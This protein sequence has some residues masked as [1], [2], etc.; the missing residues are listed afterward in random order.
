MRAYQVSAK[1]LV[2]LAL[3]TAVFAACAVLFYDRIGGALLQR[4]AGAKDDKAAASEEQQKLAGISDPSVASDER[5]NQEV[6]RAMSTGVVNITTTT[7]VRD[8]FSVYETT[9]GSGSGSI[10]D[11]E[12]HILTNYHVIE[13]AREIQVSLANNKKYKA[14][15]LGFD[16]DNDLAVL[17]IDAP[18]AELQPIPQGSSKD[19][20]VGQKVLAIGNPFGFDRT[21][22]TGI[23]SGLSRPI[24]SEMTG[25][26]IE[27][28]IQTDAAINPGNSGGPL[29]DSR[30]RQIGINTLIISPSGGSV[31]IG[32]A[33]P[34]EAAKRIIPD[35]LAYGRVR[36][37]KLGIVPLPLFARLSEALNLPVQEGLLVMQAEPGGSAE[38]A[39]IQGGNERAQLGRQ[40]I[41]IGG[42]VITAIDGQPVKSRDDLDRVLNSK[43]LGDTVQVEF[44]RNGR[45]QRVNVTLLESPSA[46][47]SGA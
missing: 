28:V 10:I 29:L 13:E 35:I 18:A 23:V 41:L 31:G 12:G 34:I 19:L 37:P 22:T 7:L 43:N 16:Q 39:G 26:L 3:L 1:Q 6:Y 36:K 27:G 40:V 32:F 25:R 21:L 38:R 47:R 14:R 2:S 44:Y 5:N 9:G 11:K 30:G 24:R 4:M 45:K 15:A 8:F 17:K 46:K 33:V 42:D 20:F